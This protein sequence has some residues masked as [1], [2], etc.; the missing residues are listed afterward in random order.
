MQLISFSNTRLSCD[1][2]GEKNCGIKGKSTLKFCVRETDSTETGN[3]I[4]LAMLKLHHVFL[5]LDIY[6]GD[7]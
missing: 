7:L 3:G 2:F 6:E 1:A 4:S 5:V